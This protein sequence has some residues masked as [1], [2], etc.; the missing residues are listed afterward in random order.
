MLNRR[1]GAGHEILALVAD[2][3]RYHVSVKEVST[4]TSGESVDIELMI[5]CSLI[6]DAAPAVKS[7]KNR[8]RNFDMTTVLTLTS[9]MDYVDFRRIP[10]DFFTHRVY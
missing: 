7:K 1:S 5:E 3:P 10:Y 2:L 4:N 8:K 6:L 9:D